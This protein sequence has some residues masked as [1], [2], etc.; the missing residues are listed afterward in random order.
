SQRERAL[1]QGIT[2]MTWTFD[3]LQ[4]LNAYFNFGKLGVLADR[5]ET[6]FSGEKTSS[7][8]HHIGCGTDRLWVSWPLDS[9]RVREKMK[10]LR[11]WKERVAEFEHIGPLI[12]VGADNDPQRNESAE[13]KEKLFVEIP[14]DINTIQ[15]ENPEL[16]LRWREA[17]RWAFTQ[18]VASGYLVE[19]FYGSARRDHPVGVYLLSHGK[20][21][22]DFV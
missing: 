22:K 14:A 4:S 12:F 19:E 7:F 3:P 10:T 8:L 6:N 16:A 20:R 5:Y 1:A 9:Q 11:S 21:V 15:R 17:T 18:A 13:G 2:R